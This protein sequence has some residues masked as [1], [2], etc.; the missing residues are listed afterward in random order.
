MDNAKLTR[1]TEELKEGTVTY[2]QSP[3]MVAFAEECLLKYFERFGPK[4][5]GDL[6]DDF[7]GEPGL[8]ECMTNLQGR[9]RSSPFYPALGRLVDKQQVQYRQD[10]TGDIWY[11]LK[12]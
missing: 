11:S 2:Q 10:E 9:W 8:Y 7:C 4:H 3:E 1:H 12:A 6:E 5:P